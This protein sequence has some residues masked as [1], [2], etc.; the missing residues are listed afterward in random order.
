MTLSLRKSLAAAT[1]VAGTLLL[2]NAASAADWMFAPSYYSH[3]DSIGYSFPIPPSSRSAY[4]PAVV[5]A[6]PRFAI[7]GGHRVNNIILRNGNS[8]DRTTIREDWFD[9]GY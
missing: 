8:W 2:A 7:R 4:R 9:V 1:I 3:V 6:H 5:G